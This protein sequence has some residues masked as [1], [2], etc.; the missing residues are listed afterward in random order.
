MRSRWVLVTAALV[1]VVGTGC[2]SDDDPDPVSAAELPDNLCAAVP[3]NVVE[4]WGLSEDEHRTAPAGDQSVATC[5]MS[6]TA[7]D[8]PVLLAI[9]LTSYGGADAD[10]VRD[11]VADEV[12]ASCDDL[13]QQGDGRFEAED[14]RCSSEADDAV[15][16]ISTAV[17]AHGVVTVTMSHSG[18]M[19]QLLPAEV[20]G[21]SGTIANTEP[22]ELS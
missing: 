13:E 7:A 9:T 20:V 11:L 18:Q 22:G 15:T 12:A 17:P 6:G 3:D 10:A 21:L 16:E 1:A 14:T 19:S 5:S 8:A 2:S 4:R